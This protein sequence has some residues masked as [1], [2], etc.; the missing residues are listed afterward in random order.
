MS[1]NDFKSLMIDEMRELRKTMSAILEFIG[2]S[3]RDRS[4]IHD[5][6]D[7]HADR[8]EKHHIRIEK[9]ETGDQKK[10]LGH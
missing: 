9:L 3:R 4:A 7:E 10:K 8:F 6:L 2:D 1:E 5:K